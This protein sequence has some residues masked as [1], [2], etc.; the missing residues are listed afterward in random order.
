MS[1]VAFADQM[2]YSR[3]RAQTG[4]RPMREITPELLE[5]PSPDGKYR[6][7]SDYIQHC[8]HLAGTGDKLG[9][10]IGFS[11]GTRVA[12]WKRGRGGRPSIS[13]CLRLAKLTG[14]SPIA[15]LTMAGHHE[16]AELMQELLSPPEHP[17][18]SPVTVIQTEQAIKTMQ[19]LLDEYK[20]Q[21][22]ERFTGKDGK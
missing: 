1:A 9:R 6:N 4:T 11:S 19:D 7:F 14:D 5:N 8:I 2:T 13:S 3:A 22:T 10:M 15:V 18:L 17:A 21:F 12:D 16:E 20:R